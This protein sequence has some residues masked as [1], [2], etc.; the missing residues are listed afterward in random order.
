MEYFLW[1]QCSQLLR[2][3]DIM[4][5]LK[6]EKFDLVIVEAFEYCLF[7]VAEKPG[8]PFVSTLP[9]SFGTVD[10]GLTSPLSYVPVFCSLSTDHMDFWGQVKNFLMFF[11]FSTIKEHFPEGSRSVLSHLLKKAELCFVNS[12][13]AFGFAWPL[14][15]NTVLEAL[16]SISPDCRALVLTL[17]RPGDGSGI[18]P[19]PTNL[20]RATRFECIDSEPLL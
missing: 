20:V 5:S 9:S 18:R 2:R 19:G 15:P 14:L 3:N 7:L 10:F 1:F 13:F 11:Y 8:K 6:T 16:S 4:N 12:N 17:P